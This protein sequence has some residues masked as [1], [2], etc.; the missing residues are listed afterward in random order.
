MK[1]EII[2]VDVPHRALHLSKLPSN[3][4]ET[5]IHLILDDIL[6][7]FTVTNFITLMIK[8]IK[9][10]GEYPFFRENNI[11]EQL[12]TLEWLIPFTKEKRIVYSQKINSA[13]KTSTVVFPRK[14]MIDLMLYITESTGIKKE[15]FKDYPTKFDTLE[16]G[17]EKI[18][19][20]IQVHIN[21]D[22]GRHGIT[23]PGKL[24]RPISPNLSFPLA[25]FIVKLSKYKFS[26]FKVQFDYN[27]LPYYILSGAITN[28]EFYVKFIAKLNS[29][30]TD[31]EEISITDKEKLQILY[32]DALRIF[33]YK[34]DYYYSS[35]KRE[36]IRNNIL[37]MF[38]N[39]TKGKGNLTSIKYTHIIPWEIV[40]DSL[41]NKTIGSP[42]GATDAISNFMY[43]LQL[44]YSTLIRLLEIFIKKGEAK[45]NFAVSKDA[46]LTVWLT[47]IKKD[48]NIKKLVRFEYNQKLRKFYEK[49]R[50]LIYAKRVY[51]EQ[52][53]DA[54]LK[55]A[56]YNNKTLFDILP[57]D[58]EEQIND[59]ISRIHKRIESWILTQGCIHYSYLLKLSTS[60]G[61]VKFQLLKK[62]LIFQNAEGYLFCKLCSGYVMCVHEFYLYQNEFENKDIINE[63][64]TLQKNTAAYVICKFCGGVLY[65]KDNFVEEYDVGMGNYANVRM[66]DDPYK[67]LLDDTRE[68]LSS[69]IMFS[70]KLSPISYANALYDIV[71][72]KIKNIKE[73]RGKYTDSQK[74]R[75]RV[76]VNRA[77]I[78]AKAI[79]MTKKKTHIVKFDMFQRPQINIKQHVDSMILNAARCM[80]SSSFVSFITAIPISDYSNLADLSVNVVYLIQKFFTEMM[81]GVDISVQEIINVNQQTFTKQL[82]SP[83]DYLINTI[84]QLSTKDEII[85]HDKQFNSKMQQIGNTYM[86]ILQN[87][88]KIMKFPIPLHTNFWGSYLIVEANLSFVTFIFKNNRF[89]KIYPKFI[90]PNIQEVKTANISIL[91][92][93]W[94]LV[95]YTQEDIK[96][97]SLKLLPHSIDSKTISCK[98]CKK[99]YT[100][101][102]TPTDE[103]VLSDKEILN[104]LL[105]LKNRPF[106]TKNVVAELI[107]DQIKNVDKNTLDS[108]ISTVFGSLA[109]T[110][111]A[112]KSILI[113]TFNALFDTTINSM[114]NVIVK[115]TREYAIIFGKNT[116]MFSSVLEQKLKNIGKLN[117][118]EFPIKE[119][120]SI[121][122][123]QSSDI[124]IKMCLKNIFLKLISSL[125]TNKDSAE[126]IH[127]F[128]QNTLTERKLLD[129]TAAD[130][131]RFNKNLRYS[132]LER[133][134]KYMESDE[135]DKVKTGLVYMI[136]GEQEEF[137]ETIRESNELDNI[138]DLE[139]T[140]TERNI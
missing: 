74:K 92:H 84:L 1:D 17:W 133:W 82:I 31:N 20:S 107:I 24:L 120:N 16:W 46:F 34:H 53:I 23:I 63:L 124:D 88:D 76:L 42:F 30:L 135:W 54:V 115:F 6:P 25:G 50:L 62:I 101:L 86:D 13:H 61:A 66:S 95:C 60:F 44:G 45:F 65:K 36:V 40:N 114:I 11:I 102:A 100:L 72:P 122:L 77:A 111:S 134:T 106:Y 48:Q 32:D 123:Q 128:M 41:I 94:D 43:C 8:L 29:K 132:T 38:I 18:P 22:I 75:L 116:T 49:H 81:T 35:L 19:N 130:I 121:L 39:N 68:L 9:E 69:Y 51:S 28:F 108:L 110:L 55:I 58:A 56:R 119:L 140:L 105:T 71:K 85:E 90:F 91:K 3:E 15:I 109:T 97:K 98:R 139:R 126:I 117:E 21:T 137:L 127:V 89:E 14:H 93:I 5:A 104:E 57:Q 78:F 87:I 136:G 103:D 52:V 118:I 12:L 26:Q 10:N 2:E 99:K 7:D 33:K 138:N 79:Y 70:P 125:V 64:K 4:I 27:M 47:Q 96:N 37:Q 129:V 83:L 80:L 113:N 59:T 131:E 73:F 67:E 112:N